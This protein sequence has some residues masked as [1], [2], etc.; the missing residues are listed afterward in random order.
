MAKRVAY[1]TA[2]RLADTYNL[3]N[4]LHS[5]QTLGILKIL[6]ILIASFSITLVPPIAVALIY[7]EDTLA[8]FLSSLV[9][10]LATGTLLWFPTRKYQGELRLRDGFLVVVLI[11]VVLSFMAAIPF[12]LADN[13]SMRLIDALFEATSGLTTTGA[14]ILTGLDDLPYSILFYRQ[15]LQWLGGMGIIVLAVAVMPALGVGGMQLYRAETP[16]PM[17]DNKLTPRITET[18]KAIWYLY[19]GLTILCGVSYFLAGMSAFDAI[20]HAFSTVAIGGFSTH[21]ASLGYFNDSRIYLLACVFMILAG[22]NFALHFSAVR[23]R[24][25]SIYLQDPEA[26]VY[27]CLLACAVLITVVML[28]SHEIYAQPAGKLNEEDITRVNNWLGE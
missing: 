17:K 15:Q 4:T 25:F 2:S 21:D 10:M 27:F 28:T 9:I 6:G 23:Y 26:R 16:G 12:L 3:S 19:L 22:L 1:L 24:R 8:V 5:M 20:S 13:P 14:T 18:A 11:W 7:G